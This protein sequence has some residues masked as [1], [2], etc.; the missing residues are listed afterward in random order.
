MLS[1]LGEPGI[2]ALDSAG[3]NLKF[4]FPQSQ[5]MKEKVTQAD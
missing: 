4:H 2:D 3:Q 5:E 1:D